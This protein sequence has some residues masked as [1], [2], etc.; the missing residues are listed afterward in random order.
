[1]FAFL[2]YF[3]NIK[4]LIELGLKK[5]NKFVIER[6]AIEIDK[7]MKKGEENIKDMQRT[8]LIKI[9]LNVSILLMTVL[10]SLF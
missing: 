4:T 6:S 8:A 10:I 3:L 5:G 1:M 2:I 9:C 7:I